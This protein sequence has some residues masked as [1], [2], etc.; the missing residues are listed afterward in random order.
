MYKISITKIEK[1]KVVENKYQKIADSSNELDKGAI[2]GY[3]P[4]ETEKQIETTI[5]EQSVEELNLFEVI[6]NYLYPQLY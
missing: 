3:V 1:E 6:A 2:Y 5:L 4:L